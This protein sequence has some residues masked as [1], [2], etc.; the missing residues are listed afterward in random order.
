MS[1][2]SDYYLVSSSPTP[3]HLVFLLHG[4]GADAQNILFLA[5]FWKKELPH[6]LFVIPNAPHK[7]PDTQ[8]FMWFEVGDLSPKYLDVGVDRARPLIASFIQNIQDAYGIPPNHT[9]IM[10]FSQ[11]AMLALAT[12]LLTQKNICRSIVAYSGG[13]YTGNCSLRPIKTEVCLIHGAQD[14]VVPKSASEWAHRTLLQKG[15]SASCHIIPHLEHH[16]NVKG[17][18]IGAQFIKQRMV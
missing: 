3:K 14:L 5:E 16:I 10:G 11:G 18:Q 4:Y 13:L 17:I 7:M 8:G 15:I 12:G 6:T 1:S 2:L 9:H